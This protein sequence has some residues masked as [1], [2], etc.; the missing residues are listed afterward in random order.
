[1]TWQG[2]EGHDAIAARFAVAEAAGRVAGSYLFVG[3]PGVGKA[4]FARALALALVCEHPAEGLTACRQCASC[5][6]AL[7]GTHPDI[8]IVEKPPERATIPLDALIGSPDQRL[9]TGFCWRLLLRPALARRKVSIL[10]DAD[11]LSD[12]AANC[13]LK[14]LEE[15]PPGSVIIL[16]GTTLERQL[17]TIRSRC[18]TVRFGPLAPETIAAILT[19]EQSTT[20]D[21]PG[22]TDLSGI[23]QAA[24]GS[25]QRARLLLNDDVAVFRD[26]LLTLLAGQPLPGVDLSRETLTVVEAAGK[27]APLRRARLRIILE[28]AVEFFRASLRQAAGGSLPADPTMAAAVQR[29]QLPGED[30][31]TCLRH[32]LDALTGIERNA[33]LGI[34]I[35]AWSAKL[36]PQPSRG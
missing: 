25:L 2:I 31:D 6:Q 3:Q 10:L 18:Q 5:I 9:R 7:A 14:T 12:E 1:M 30:A 4:T 33:N 26:R 27:E 29:R 34:L 32:T 36:E 21:E 24:G 16:V 11:H 19:H 35:D 22:V 28:Q 20:A 15:P 13:L 8:D 23:A 17:P